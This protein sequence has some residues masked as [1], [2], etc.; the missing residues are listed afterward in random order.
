MVYD[1]RKPRGNRTLSPG[2]AGG[3]AYR[4][5][6]YPLEFSGSCHFKKSGKWRSLRDLR[7]IKKIIH[8]M[9]SLQPG[10]PL[11]SLLPKEWL[12]I[13]INLK[14]CLFTIPLLECDK[15]KFAFSVLTFN[16]SCSV[17]DIIGISCHKE[18]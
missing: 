13:E 1:K 14:N 5:V 10:I 18:C 17:K 2:A 15:E 9:S 12:I 4:G 8:P 16:R 11:P 7:A 3:S 6:Y